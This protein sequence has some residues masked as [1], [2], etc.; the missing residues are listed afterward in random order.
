MLL[1]LDVA[2]DLTIGAF[3]APKLAHTGAAHGARANAAMGILLRICSPIRATD[4]RASM[5]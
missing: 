4:I 1:A 5:A 3:D 2:H